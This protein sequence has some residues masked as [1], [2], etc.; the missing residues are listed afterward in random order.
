[1]LFLTKPDS[2]DAEAAFRQAIHA[3]PTYPDPYLNLGILFERRGE[4]Q[5]AVRWYDA[6]EKADVSGA[7]ASRIRPRIAGVR[8]LLSEM[9]TSEGRRM[10][11]YGHL[12]SLAQEA[13]EQGNSRS[14]QAL[15]DQ[16]EQQVPRQWETEAMRAAIYAR[17]GS[18]GRA[19]TAILNARA[20]APED[21]KRSLR[22]AYL[23]ILAQ[24]GRSAD[25]AR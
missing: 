10:V 15:L 20:L 12:I 5:T 21:K 9:Q 16:A 2:T 3:D 4:Y 17:T 24:L 8:T 23:D 22:K 25:G 1:V 7:L 13:R 6:C 14:A 18:W 11:N 19:K